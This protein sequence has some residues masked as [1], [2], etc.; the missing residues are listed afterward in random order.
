MKKLVRLINSLKLSESSKLVDLYLKFVDQLR[1]LENHETSC[2]DILKMLITRSVNLV[3]L[4]GYQ[5]IFLLF[6][7]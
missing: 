7:K 3:F 5:I 6:R 1:I 4:G 2:R